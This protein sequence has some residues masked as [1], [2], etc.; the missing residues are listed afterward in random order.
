MKAR[1]R[2]VEDIERA[3]GVAFR[4]LERELT[5]CASPPDSVVADWPSVM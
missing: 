5:R 1:R 4:E 2:F 3:P